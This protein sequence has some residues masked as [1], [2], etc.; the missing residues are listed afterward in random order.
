MNSATL[1]E[2]RILESQ[3]NEGRGVSCVRSIIFF[4][5]K[6]DRISAEITCFNEGDKICNYPEIQR[7]LRSE[8]PTYDAFLKRFES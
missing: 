5:E 7:L 6:E 2:L 3:Q 4:L 1:L 8:F